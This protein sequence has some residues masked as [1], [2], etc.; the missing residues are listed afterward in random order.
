M[1]QNEQRVGG[2]QLGLGPLNSFMPLGKS[3]YLPGPHFTNED[4]T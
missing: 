3:L 1:E 4:L 2:Q